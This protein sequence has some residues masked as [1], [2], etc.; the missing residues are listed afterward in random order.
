MRFDWYQ[1]TVYDDEKSVL[2]HLSGY[3]NE[4]FRDADALAKKARYDHGYTLRNTSTGEEVKVFA[5]GHNGIHGT[6]FCATGE[7]A[8]IVS[9]AIRRQWAGGHHVTRA[10]AC[11]D[12][13]GPDLFRSIRR[14][15]LRVAKKHSIAA[16]YEADAI[17]QL[18]GAT[19][20]LGAPS[21]DYRARGYQ[22]G[23]Q[24]R[25][26]ALAGM[27]G[28]KCDVKALLRDVQVQLQDG[29]LVDARDLVRV[30]AQIRPPTKKGK[31]ALATL[32]P[33]Q[34]FAFSPWL[35]DLAQSVLDMNLAKIDIRGQKVTD[36]DHKVRWMLKQYGPV[37]DE[38]ID[39][40][41]AE[42][43]GKFLAA[44]RDKSKCEKGSGVWGAAPI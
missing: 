38:L 25:S 41:G 42:G 27:R 7:N 28:Y 1:G 14:K 3:F 29:T 15:M 39:S 36:L 9:Q 13:H 17:D 40:Y 31:L 33:E 26:Q 22:K 44:E 11:Q 8:I 43:M 12:L 23:L 10:D 5:G 18:A 4:V 2:S 37:L 34:C 6:H 20:Y 21:S 35:V 19:Q 16:K 24:Q 30:E 32:E